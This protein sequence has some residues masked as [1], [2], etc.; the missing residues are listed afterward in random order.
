M[1]DYSCLNGKIK[2]VFCSQANFAQALGISA[3]SLSKKLNGITDFTQK[4]MRQACSL[5]GIEDGEVSKYFFTEAVKE[6]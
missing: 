1:F 3:T 5:L 6:A 2:E 4:E